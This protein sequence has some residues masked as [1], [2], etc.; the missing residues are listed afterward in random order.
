MVS[1]RVTAQIDEVT[2]RIIEIEADTA[3]K[4]RKMLEVVLLNQD[5]RALLG[6]AKLKIE[7]EA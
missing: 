5:V 1:V 6:L 4:A 3:L 2:S 7:G